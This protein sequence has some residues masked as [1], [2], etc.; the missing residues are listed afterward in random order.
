MQH[1]EKL[2]KQIK[3]KKEVILKIENENQEYMGMFK[4]LHIILTL[5]IIQNIISIN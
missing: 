3:L 4:W 2:Q 5:V 1:I